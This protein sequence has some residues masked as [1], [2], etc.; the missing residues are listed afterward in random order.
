MRHEK[1]IQH[2]SLNIGYE[3]HIFPD[4]AEKLGK[5]H[6]MV[7]VEVEKF[8]DLP[9]ETFGKIIPACTYAVFTHRLADGGYSG[10]NERMDK[11]LKESKYELALPLSIQCFDER[12]KG[13]NQPDSQIDF[14][15]PI[16]PR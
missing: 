3:V 15:I 8:E 16:K 13:G 6:V 11:W 7:G 2:A 5:Y 1:A 9:L 10:A 12:F 4:T 14:Y